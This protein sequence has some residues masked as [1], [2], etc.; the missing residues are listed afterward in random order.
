[1]LYFFPG[2]APLWS[3]GV[4]QNRPEFCLPCRL[5]KI[6]SAWIL[7]F[8]PMAVTKVFINYKFHVLHVLSDEWQYVQPRRSNLIKSLK[9]KQA[10]RQFGTV[11]HR[12]VGGVIS[13]RFRLNNVKGLLQ[14]SKLLRKGRGSKYVRNLRGGTGEENYR[15]KSWLIKLMS[16]RSGILSP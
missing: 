9:N 16:R 5:C 15:S 8:S 7:A 13:I 2:N 1:M 10:C 4:R 11:K 6:S 12:G 14:G 3:D